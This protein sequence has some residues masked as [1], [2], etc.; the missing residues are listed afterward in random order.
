MIDKRQHLLETALQLFYANGIQAVGINEVLKTSGIAKKTLYHHFSSKDALV[1]AALEARD[2]RFCAWFESLI[3]GSLSNAELVE[4]MFKGL[5]QWFNNEIE[6]LDAFRGCFFINT[7]AEFCDST[8]P[9]SSYCKEHKLK[10]RQIIAKHM[11][12]SDDNLLDALCTLKEGSIVM[13]YVCQD[14][15]AAEKAFKTVTCLLDD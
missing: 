7:S 15:Q 4:R 13:A 6:K 10:I 2:E 5:S 12:T 1:L 11:V 8:G 3:E 14:K 9:I